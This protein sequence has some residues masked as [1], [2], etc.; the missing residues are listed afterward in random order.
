MKIRS[1]LP[2]GLSSAFLSLSLEEV[3]YD[4][5][6]PTTADV[7]D[8]PTRAP[9]DAGQRCRAG[10]GAARLPLSTTHPADRYGE[11]KPACR[12]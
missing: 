9:G 5:Q 8:P 1:D 12:R 3:W 2:L 4:T 7:S 11:E 6:S 10:G